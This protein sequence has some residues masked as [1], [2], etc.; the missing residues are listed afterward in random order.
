MR[1]RYLE[2]VELYVGSLGLLSVV[3]GMLWRDPLNFGLICDIV[4]A[5]VFVIS[6]AIYIVK[7]HKRFADIQATLSQQSGQLRAIQ[8]GYRIDKANETVTPVMTE[9]KEIIKRTEAK[10]DPVIVACEYT[11]SYIVRDYT[12]NLASAI[13]AGYSNVDRKVEIEDIAP[14]CVF[15]EKFAQSIPNGSVYIG[16]TL[17]TSE[18]AWEGND[19]YNEWGKVL[20]KR[21]KNK[22]IHV[23]RLWYLGN[24]PLTDSLKE[25]IKAQQR[26]GIIGRI[27]SN[28]VLE[29]LRLSDISL[30]WVGQK[31]KRKVI[32]FD[33]LARNPIEVLESSGYESL[34]GLQFDVFTSSYLKC[35]TVLRKAEIARHARQFSDAWHRSELA[36]T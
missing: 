25:Q 2:Y 13:K 8:T 20:R 35:V 16:I 6:M 23:C 4:G 32:D 14:V 28:N 17:L 10:P 15:L 22:E 24:S 1:P 12:Q 3:G 11:L 36:N 29:N 18:Q 21:A 7:S 27:L 26:D 31:E 34:S 30:V 9:L 33:E 5:V 19:A